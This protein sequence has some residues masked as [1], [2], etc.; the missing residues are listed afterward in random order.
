MSKFVT[1]VPLPDLLQVYMQEIQGVATVEKI[2]DQY[3]EI[4]FE[5]DTEFTEYEMGRAVAEL[6]DTLASTGGDPLVSIPK[7][8]EVK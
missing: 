7:P 8:K 5:V 6:E 4:M 1:R 2:T 3:L